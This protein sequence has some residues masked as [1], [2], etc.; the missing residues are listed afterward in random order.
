MF[1]EAQSKLFEKDLNVEKTV[2][3]KYILLKGV[4]LFNRNENV[5]FSLR[6]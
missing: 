6:L 4:S 5:D 1:C 2:V 3:K